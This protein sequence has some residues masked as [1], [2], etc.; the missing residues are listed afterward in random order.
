MK[1]RQKLE[2]QI[3]KLKLFKNF[4]ADLIREICEFSTIE[5]Y[6]KGDII[7]HQGDKGDAMYI[8]LEGKVK[9]CRIE[10]N[11]KIKIAELS[12]GD[13]FGEMEIFAP[14][15]SGRAGEAVA[16]TRTRLLKMGKKELLKAISSGAKSATRFLLTLNKVL[17]QR[18]RKMDE[19]YTRLFIEY[20]GKEKVDE[21]RTLKE[22][23]LKEWKI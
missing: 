22:K 8:I 5:E 6:S 7:F 16:M 23:I 1:C 12:K 2:N 19:A 9:I 14:S 17:I 15:R 21:L 3:S 18:L 11:Q 10:K 4:P 13:F 20:H